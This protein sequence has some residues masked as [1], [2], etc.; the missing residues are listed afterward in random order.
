M[1][2]RQASTNPLNDYYASFLFV[3]IDSTFLVGSAH[4]SHRTVSVST[5]QTRCPEALDQWS[6][7]LFEVTNPTSSYAHPEPLVKNKNMT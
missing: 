7:N 1:V 6:L 3:D 5:A 4:T 2:K